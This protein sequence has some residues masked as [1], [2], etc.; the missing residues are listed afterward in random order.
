MTLRGRAGDQRVARANCNTTEE[1]DGDQS[2]RE[3][4]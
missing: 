3:P 2:R 1:L 4:R